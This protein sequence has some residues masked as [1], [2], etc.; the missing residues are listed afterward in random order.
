M[1]D[2]KK[3]VLLQQ[4]SPNGY[5]SF[6]TPL[7]GFPSILLSMNFP[8]SSSLLTQRPVLGFWTWLRFLTA[9]FLCPSPDGGFVAISHQF[10]ACYFSGFAKACPRP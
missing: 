1:F 7:K 8:V 3:G 9:P 6:L 10:N 5:F 2:N 4:H